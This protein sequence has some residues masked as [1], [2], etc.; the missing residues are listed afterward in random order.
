MATKRSSYALLNGLR[1]HFLNWESDEEKFPVLLLHGLAS[2]ARIWD[3]VGPLLADAGCKVVAAD[4]RGHGLTDKPSSGYDFET[5]SRDVAAML[6][7][8]NLQ[9]PILVGHSW[10]ASVVLDFAARFPFGSYAPRGVI[11]VDG[12]LASLK[13][14]N[15]DTWEK[16]RERLQ[17]PPLA[18]MA[19]E[20]FLERLS[21]GQIG[22]IPD[23]DDLQIIL[24]NFEI[25]EDET[26]YPHLSKKNHLSVLKALYEF[27]AFNRLGLVKCLVQAILAQPANPS[28]NEFYQR[29]TL[30]AV[31]AAEIKPDIDIVW[32]PNTIH[33]I[34]L[35]RAGDLADMIS[36][37][38]KGIPTT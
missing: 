12:G 26:I 14:G 29:K 3:K 23:E 33:D 5:L 8:W 4:Q 10:G 30:G 22:W 13:N 34:P 1:F 38:V 16:I 2:N 35:Q 15:G 37:F 7:F 9:R 28:N 17:P 19:L 21:A 6:D 24:A 11:M 32:M 36:N 18:G 20:T 31:R 25:K 27:D